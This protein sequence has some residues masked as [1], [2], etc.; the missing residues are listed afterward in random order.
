M[1]L[2]HHLTTIT[3]ITI[4]INY[5]YK[6]ACAIALNLHDLADVVLE[7]SR[8]LHY[9]SFRMLSDVLFLIFM[10]TWFIQRCILFPV[11]T[12]AILVFDC[13]PS[14]PCYIML[15]SLQFVILILDS[16]WFW[17]I[18]RIVIRSCLV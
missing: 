8:F 16:I 10:A 2:I 17:R 13:P 4:S 18:I 1:M 5:S 3:L 14:K 7:I 11:S 12:I 15:I 6:T 9:F